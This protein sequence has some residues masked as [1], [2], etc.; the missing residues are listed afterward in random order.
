MK[1]FYEESK[2]N[3][4][5]Y[6]G[7][8]ILILSV[9]TLILG[10]I[11]LYNINIQS[12]KIQYGI[13]EA[14]RL[15]NEIITQE[16]N[17]EENNV[18]KNNLDITETINNATKFVVGVS[19]LKDN[20]SSVFINNSVSKMGIGSGIIISENGYILTNEHVSGYNGGTCYITLEDGKQYQAKVVWSDSDMDL[21]ILKVNMKFLD[22]GKLG[23]SNSTKVGQG[24]FA[25]GNPIGFEFQKTVT[26]GIISAM[27]RTVVFKEGEEEIYLS[28]LIQTDA[29][30]NPGNSGGPLINEKG[31]VIGVTTVKITSA[32][33]MGFAVPVNTIKP[34]L[35]QFENEGKF[36]EAEIGIFAYDKNVIPYLNTGVKFDSGIYVAQISLDS[37]AYR[38][39]IEIGDIIT[40]IDGKELNK[41]SDLKEYMYSKKVGDKVKLSIIRNRKDIEI[42]VT[43]IEKN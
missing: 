7:K 36:N 11:F 26:S 28:N 39:G 24:V 32:D 35:Q 33:G 13:V 4:K 31:E 41:M 25:I 21:S 17:K 29:T 12:N 18:N 20:G 16:V 43:L 27:N 3:K 5:V 38:S 22:V 6:K 19:K 2:K 37:P 42:D 8:T 1:V 10:V 40:K 15:N 14:K 34:I 9:Y 30:I 23:D